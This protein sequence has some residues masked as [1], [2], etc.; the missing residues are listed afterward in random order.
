MELEMGIG[1]GI[2]IE[3]KRGE[4]RYICVFVEKGIKCIYMGMGM[5]VCM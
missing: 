1:I 4:C 2:G 5:C 3:V